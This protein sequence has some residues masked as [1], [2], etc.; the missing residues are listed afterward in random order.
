[1]N[2]IV[3]KLPELVVL[4]FLIRS[5]TVGR[6]DVGN[7]ACW[8]SLLWFCNCFTTGRLVASFLFYVFVF[9]SLLTFVLILF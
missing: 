5:F 3:G 1:M 6:E 9:Y 2:M 8:R 7:T 4:V